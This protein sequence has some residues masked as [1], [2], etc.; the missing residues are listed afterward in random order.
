MAVNLIIIFV[1]NMHN[2]INILNKIYPFRL[3]DN[4]ISGYSGN[5]LKI[6]INSFISADNSM[7]RSKP[8]N[9]ILS[10]FSLESV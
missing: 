8:L 4:F 3:K 5:F 6:T 10:A 1:Y 9:V 2:S 7:Y